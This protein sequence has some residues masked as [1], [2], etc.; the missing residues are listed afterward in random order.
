MKVSPAQYARTLL[1]L[2]ENKTEKEISAVVLRFAEV[3]KRDGQLKNA[4]IITEKFSDL[5]NEKHGIVEAEVITKSKIDDKE[6]KEVE[7]YIR[8][9][10][11]A[12]EVVVKNVLDESIQ[13]GMIVRVGD[14]VLD[15]SVSGQLKKLKKILSN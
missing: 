5:Y 3:I 1:E 8:K 13:G 11:A 12:K 15:G 10:Y 6:L 4:K 9:K 14:E 7:N 2:T